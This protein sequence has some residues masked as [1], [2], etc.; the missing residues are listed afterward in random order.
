M[1]GGLFVR[2]PVL[3]RSNMDK[4]AIHL[5][6]LHR[7]LFGDAPTVFILEVL[8]RAVITYLTLLVVI[9]WLGKRMRGQVTILEMAVM[10]T[11]G[12]IVSTAMQV[13][14][15]G[16]L[17]ATLVLLCTLSF[18]RG[19]SWLE[20][21]ST[22]VERITQGQISILVR[23]GTVQQKE[24]A[25]VRIS[26]LQLFADLRSKGIYNLGMVKRVYLEASG[27]LTI[28]KNKEEKPGLATFPTEDKAIG[29]KYKP[30]ELLTCFNCGLIRQV[31][32]TQPCRECG[33]EHWV[34]A[35]TT[36]QE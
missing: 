5:S 9:R 36:L 12:A 21:K 29:D 22:R 30:L 28:F 6:D 35:T 27:M 18:E 20:F 11:L 31:G 34:H 3:L 7:I 16:I 15:S 17:M 13:P 4:Q 32:Q 26:N 24:M 33:H 10:L 1:S 14:E 19:I 8:I 2:S 25:K 23:D